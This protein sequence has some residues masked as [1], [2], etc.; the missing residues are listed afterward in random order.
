MAFP[1]R[2]GVVGSVGV[3]VGRAVYA[4][5]SPFPETC[6]SGRVSVEREEKEDGEELKNG[7]GRAPGDEWSKDGENGTE[8]EGVY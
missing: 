4:W 6:F 5:R 1:S 2:Y 7:D 3:P 8:I